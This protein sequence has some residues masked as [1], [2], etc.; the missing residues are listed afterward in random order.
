MHMPHN[1][2]AGGFSPPAPTPHRM[3]VRTVYL[4]ERTNNFQLK[5]KRKR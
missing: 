1:R 5:P 4:T 3:R 2:V